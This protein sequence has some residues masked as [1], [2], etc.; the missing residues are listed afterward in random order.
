[1]PKDKYEET[2]RCHTLENGVKPVSVL[3]VKQCQAYLDSSP[4]VIHYAWIK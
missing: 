1:M 2:D 3:L 4:Y